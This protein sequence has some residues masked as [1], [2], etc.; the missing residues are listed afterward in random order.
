MFGGMKLSSAPAVVANN[1]SPFWRMDSSADE[2]MIDE[3][4]IAENFR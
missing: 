4:M 2:L 1:W 3:L